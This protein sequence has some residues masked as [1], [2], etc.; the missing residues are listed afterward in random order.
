MVFFVRYKSLYRHPDYI[1]LQPQAYLQYPAVLRSMFTDYHHPFFSPLCSLSFVT[2]SNYLLDVMQ[3]CPASGSKRPFSSPNS[4]TRYTETEFLWPYEIPWCKFWFRSLQE[5][6]EH[7]TLSFV[8]AECRS[9]KNSSFC[10]GSAC[11]SLDV[12]TEQFL[13]ICET[14]MLAGIYGQKFHLEDGASNNLR[15][16]AFSTSARCYQPE[17]ISA[18]IYTCS[19]YLLQF[20]YQRSSA[21]TQKIIT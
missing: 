10:L 18:F 3:R 11:L 8:P 12:N 6:S 20:I 2:S 19:E 21:R 15:S 7:P 1:N 16:A 9:I 17:T 5:L 4:E 13:P 14:V